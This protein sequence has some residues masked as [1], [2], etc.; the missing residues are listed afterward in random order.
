MT[1]CAA[2]RPPS[3]LSSDGRLQRAGHRV[4][5][6]AAQARRAGRGRVLAAATAS[7]GAPAIS[8]FARALSRLPTLPW[9]PLARSYRWLPRARARARFRSSL[10]ALRAAGLSSSSGGGVTKN[11]RTSSLS[12]SSG[13]AGASSLAATTN[14][15]S[16]LTTCDEHRKPE[17]G[18]QRTVAERLTRHLRQHRAHLLEEHGRASEGDQAVVAAAQRKPLRA[19]P[20]P[21]AACPPT[22]T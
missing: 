7:A 13:E 12:S 19:G 11:L 21:C 15:N 9:S 22:E 3:R 18:E 1:V 10:A 20:A 4:A 6:S 17:A 2:P 5:L 8:V 14:K 16:R